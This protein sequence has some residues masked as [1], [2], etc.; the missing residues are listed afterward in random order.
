MARTSESYRQLTNELTR[1]Y[2]HVRWRDEP[3]GKHSRLVLRFGAV[4]RFLPYTSTETDPRG[5]RNKVSALRR[6]I[7]EMEDINARQQNETT[8]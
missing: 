3:G 7:R 2:P 6:L 5:V 1:K 4:E 8:A